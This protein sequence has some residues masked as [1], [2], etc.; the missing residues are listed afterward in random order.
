[1]K[2]SAYKFNTLHMNKF[3]LLLICL[4]LATLAQAQTVTVK[5]KSEKI[6]GAGADG[7]AEIGRAH[8]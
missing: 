7:Y 8:V 2:Q 1:M 5:S 3:S 4:S 6:N